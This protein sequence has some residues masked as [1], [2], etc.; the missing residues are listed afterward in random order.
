[1]SYPP[2]GGLVTGRRR[3]SRETTADASRRAAATGRAHGPP[4]SSGFAG[5]GRWSTGRVGCACE[6]LRVAGRSRAERRTREAEVAAGVVVAAA[7]AEVVVE[8]EE[9]EGEEEAAEVEAVE[10]AEASSR[11]MK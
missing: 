10:A 6:P 1:M 5:P 2:V 8:E 11:T 4:S 7:V 3:A 9:A